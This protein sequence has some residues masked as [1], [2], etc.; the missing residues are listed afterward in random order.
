MLPIDEADLLAELLECAPPA[1]EPPSN[2]LPIL[3]HEDDCR[4]A[5][6]TGGTV[7]KDASELLEVLLDPTA[8]TEV[9]D[10]MAERRTPQQEAVPAAAAGPRSDATA[11]PNEWNVDAR[12]ARFVGAVIEVAR[13]VLD[14]E[15]AEHAGA[16]LAGAELRVAPTPAARA[17]LTRARMLEPD[18]GG[19]RPS[20]RFTSTRAAFSALVR[21][22]PTADVSACGELTL[23]QWAAEL[24]A[25]LAGQGADAAQLRRELRR[26]KIAAF[27]ML[28]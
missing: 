4:K 7:R 22:D 26:R 27:G 21:G 9:R 18:D 15:I 19:T 13:S 16:L 5:P 11:P 25:G 10:L 28:D 12:M 2:I 20:E 1:G 24:V 8:D 14:A 3:P 17:A 23:D 6:Q